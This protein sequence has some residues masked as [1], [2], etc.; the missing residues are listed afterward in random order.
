[1]LSIILLRHGKTEGN[2]NSRYNGRTDD[3][4]CDDGVREARKAAHFPDI[5]HVYASPLMRTRQTAGICFPNAEVVTIDGLREMD[6][7]EFEG[8]T[9]AEMENDAAYRAWVAGGCVDLCPGG[10]SIPLFAKRAT[11]AF[12]GA[13]ADAIARGEE[14][15]GFSVHGG[16]IM[17]VMSAFSGSDESYHTW[18]VRNCSGYEIE[19]DEAAWAKEKRFASYRLFGEQGDRWDMIGGKPEA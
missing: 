7:G 11:A 1:M 19:L 18:Y 4:L 15:V 12:A 6:F 14:R 16:V 2:L 5:K 8:R 9:A 10:E 13:V 17:S 3:P